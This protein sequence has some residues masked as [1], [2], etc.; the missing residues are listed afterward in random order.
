MKFVPIVCRVLLG[1]AFVVFGSNGLHPFLPMPAPHAGTPDGDWSIVMASSHWLQVISFLQLLGGLL[2]L[3]GG[4]L[5]LG[6]CILCP[7]TFNIL[8]FHI[9]LTGGKQIGAGLVITALELVLIYF[10]RGS[11]AGILTTKAA[12]TT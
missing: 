9:F 11:F 7:I 8:C 4:T 3:L 2:V 1:L 12:P 6:L 10:Y 5:P